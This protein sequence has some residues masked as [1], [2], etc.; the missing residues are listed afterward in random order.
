[1]AVAGGGSVVVVT[2]G[3]DEQALDAREGHPQA[4]VLVDGV[5]HDGDAETH[6]PNSMIAV[7]KRHLSFSDPMENLAEQFP[8]DFQIL[9]SDF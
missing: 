6:R 1:M 5:G 7:S 2:I 3:S 4:P 8:S 9:P